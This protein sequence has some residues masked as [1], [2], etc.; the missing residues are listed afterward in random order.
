[1]DRL[2]SNPL[3]RSF[4]IFVSGA[5]LL[6]ISPV[7]LIVAAAIKLSGEDVFFMQD[8]A[9]LGLKPFGVLKFTT[10]P[11]GSEKLGMLAP[12]GDKRVTK[13]GY[14]LRKTKI[15]ELP[16]LINVFM[17]EMSMV[18]PRPLF[19]KQVANYEG[20]VQEAISQMRPGITGLGSLFFSSEDALL[21]TVLDKEK[22]YNTVV[23]P[24]KGLLELFYFENQT[25][26]L[27]VKIVW[28]TFLSVLKGKSILPKCT[29][30]LV[31]GFDERVESFRKCEG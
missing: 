19:S 5:I 22:F 6:V 9:G 8:R 26:W 18:G 10:M 20:Q 28:L 31:E 15:N 2:A 27:D 11:K 30:S 7:F 21:A 25:F 16:Q 3:K 13:L 1:M 23:L 29:R 14:F 4:D 17:G 12:T 24:Q